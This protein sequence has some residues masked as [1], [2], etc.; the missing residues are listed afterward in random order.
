ME[1][2]SSEHWTGILADQLETQNLISVPKYSLYTIWQGPKGLNN[3]G[4]GVRQTWVQ[5]LT[6]PPT[7][8]GISGKSQ[9]FWASGSLPIN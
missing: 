7:G 2:R 1:E 8:C 5:I 3:T 6:L 4:I 9:L